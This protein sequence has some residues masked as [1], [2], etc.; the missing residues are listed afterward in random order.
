MLYV[1]T[2]EHLEY[3][4]ITLVRVRSIIQVEF[5]KIQNQSSGVNPDFLNYDL[6]AF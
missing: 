1:R 5:F 2:R 6:I 3:I 4:L